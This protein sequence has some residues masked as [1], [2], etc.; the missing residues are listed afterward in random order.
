[1][2][3]KGRSAGR[4]TITPTIHW[5]YV[6]QQIS[7]ARC[8]SAFAKPNFL[9]LRGLELGA[10]FD[11]PLPLSVDERVQRTT[12]SSALQVDTD[13]RCHAEEVNS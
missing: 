4:I 1:M 12:K 3:W 2:P 13:E 10:C 11:V 5:K 8:D 6:R 9:K 7:R